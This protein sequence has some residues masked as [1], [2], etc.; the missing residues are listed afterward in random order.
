MVY[1]LKKDSGWC[2]LLRYY[3]LNISQTCNCVCSFFSH[4]SILSHAWFAYEVAWDDQSLTIELQLSSPFQDAYSIRE[5]HR[6][7]I[8]P[9]VMLDSTQTLLVWFQ[10]LKC[11]FSSEFSVLLKSL[12]S[13][14]VLYLLTWKDD[15]RFMGPQLKRLQYILSNQASYQIKLKRTRVA[16]QSKGNIEVYP[17]QLYDYLP[18]PMYCEAILASTSICVGRTSLLYNQY[19]SRRDRICQRRREVA[20]IMHVL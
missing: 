20:K 18:Q 9:L 8:L 16:S 4:L 3:Q 2:D 14:P 19:F 12:L 5:D 13:K 11:Q 1:C 17:L 6:I 7:L 15:C 10:Q